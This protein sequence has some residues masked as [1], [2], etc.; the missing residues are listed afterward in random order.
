V[1]VNEAAMA[2]AV[3]GLGIASTGAWGCR[4]ELESGAG[5][6]FAGMDEDPVEINAVLSGDRAAKPATRAFADYLAARPL[7]HLV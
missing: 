6:G 7:R 5:S 4:R 1:N 3:A 2:A